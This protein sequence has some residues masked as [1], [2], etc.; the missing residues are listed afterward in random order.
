MVFRTSWLDEVLC[1]RRQAAADI[2]RR[3]KKHR[4]RHIEVG[5]NFAWEK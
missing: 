2:W 5:V 1:E 3:N 4:G